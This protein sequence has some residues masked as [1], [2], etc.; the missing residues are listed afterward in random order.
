MLFEKPNNWSDEKELEG[1]LFYVQRLQELS[2][3]QSDFIEKAVGTPARKIVK[4]YLEVL[5]IEEEGVVKGLENELEVL[6]AE[7]KE[8]LST[9]TVAKSLLGNK[10]ERYL[11]AL[12]S[13]SHKDVKSTL[14]L[15][16]L[17]LSSEKYWS[18]LKLSVIDLLSTPKEKDKILNIANLTFEFLTMYGY[19]KGT[20]YHF[21]NSVFYDKERK[22]KINSISDVNIFLE[23]YDLKT[24]EYDVY[25]VCS[26]LFQD[27]S[28][29]CESFD[30]EILNEKEPEY[31]EPLEKAFFKNSQ[32][33]KSFIKCKKIKALDYLNAMR[34]AEEK[35]SLISDLFVLFHHKSKPWFSRYCLVYNHKKEQVMKLS[36]SMN[37][38]SKVNESDIEYAKEIFPVFLKN[39]SLGRDSFKRFTRGVELHALSLE[40]TESSSQILN[41][42]ICLEAL[43]ITGKGTHI[44]SVEKSVKTIVS[45]YYFKE[46]LT[47]L[48]DLL[49]RWDKEKLKE[50][51][52]SLP[53]AWQEDD[54]LVVLALV[55]LKEYE[56]IA[57][58]LLKEMGFYPLLRYKFMKLVRDFQSPSSLE[59]IKQKIENKTVRDIRRIYRIRNKI[60]H[61]GVLDSRSGN[62]VEIAHYYLDTV[63]NVI[64]Y[65]RIQHENINSIDNFLFEQNLFRAEHDSLMSDAKKSG[66][67]SSNIQNVILGPDHEAI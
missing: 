66:L 19:E 4:E 46:R 45:N 67:D 12:E 44:S 28:E 13:E 27:I 65:N 5:K 52:E 8:K 35:A 15:I 32:G 59:D 24:R 33:K 14:Q 61:Q 36:F 63:M 39:F 17:K 23:K 7:L 31:N 18:L 25:F 58:S 37:A 22:T 26:N 41:L 40:T 55:G 54:D 29:S 10:R 2:Y 50:A 42:W 1:L 34:V 30:I 9:D 21:V 11:A 38:M 56:N 64:I 51:A 53:E 49:E 20:I 60:V 43:L 47:N 48:Y 6:R 62:I 16:S 57:T 3:D